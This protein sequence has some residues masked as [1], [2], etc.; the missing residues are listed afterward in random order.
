MGLQRVM[1]A[2]R[3][4]GRL[5]LISDEFTDGTLLSPEGTVAAIIETSGI[6]TRLIFHCYDAVAVPESS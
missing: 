5:F 2:R 4:L 1:R 3:V 6:Q